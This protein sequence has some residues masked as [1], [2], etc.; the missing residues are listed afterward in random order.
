MT[1]SKYPYDHHSL[2]ARPFPSPPP[3]WISLTLRVLAQSLREILAGSE[4][5]VML[6]VTQYHIVPR[7]RQFQHSAGTEP[8]NPQIAC[9]QTLT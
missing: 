3:D 5:V 8:S 2:S 4:E 9:R 1:E 6:T 7:A